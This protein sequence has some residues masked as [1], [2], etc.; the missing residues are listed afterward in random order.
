MPPARQ[1]SARRAD[2]F[3]RYNGAYLGA[4]AMPSPGLLSGPAITAASSPA[5]ARPGTGRGECH[6]CSRSKASAALR[7]PQSRCGA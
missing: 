6:P 3:M 2:S 4:V 1:Q 5:P 7:E